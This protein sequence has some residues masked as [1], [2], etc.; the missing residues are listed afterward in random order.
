M[1]KVILGLTM[2]LDGY[3]EDIYGSVNPLYSDLELLAE[4]DMMLDSIDTTGAVV[5]S[6]KEFNM[7]ED[8]DLYADHYEYQVP[9]FVFTDTVPEKHP[10]ENDKLSFTF[11]T[12][13]IESA[14]KQAKGAAGEKDV[15]IIGSALTTPL[16]LRTKL[17]DELQVDIIPRFLGEGYRPFENLGNLNIRLERISTEEL[18]EG[19][20]H[21]SY[22]II[23]TS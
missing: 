16:C 8:S 18:P 7:A 12:N 9:I 15:N 1:S 5:M 3:A 19:R 2:S 13:G 17:I 10:R 22:S 21:I 23:P 20:I 14:I 11:I 4:T 6:F